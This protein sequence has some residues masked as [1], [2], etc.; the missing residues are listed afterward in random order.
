MFYLARDEVPPRSWFCNFY[1]K[2]HPNNDTSHGSDCHYW[3]QGLVIPCVLDWL[4][5]DA[6]YPDRI[7]IDKLKQHQTTQLASVENA[8]LLSWS[9]LH[10]T[11]VPW[12]RITT[13]N[14]CSLLQG[15]YVFGGTGMS[16]RAMNEW[17]QKGFVVSAIL[18]DRHYWVLVYVV[19][20]LARDQVREV[21]FVFLLWN[22]IRT[23]QNMVRII[24][25]DHK[26]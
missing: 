20:H 25:L 6:K 10:G 11:H 15:S 17:R 14:T 23:I 19:F 9:L 22:S 5:V 16:S 13:R 18:N 3:I 1:M 7:S 26:D 12:S 4:F 21:G 8:C 24:I 2:F